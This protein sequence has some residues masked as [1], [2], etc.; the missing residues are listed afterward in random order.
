MLNITRRRA[1]ADLLAI[2]G[3]VALDCA[4]NPVTGKNQLMLISEDEEIAIG[5]QAHPQILSQFGVYKD[6][7]IQDFMNTLGQKIAKGSQR[8]DL[9][10]TFTVLDSPVVNAFAAPGGYI[11]LNRGILAYFNDEAQ[12]AGVLGHEIGHVVARHSAAQMSKEELVNLGLG[13]G[14]IF[15]PTIQ[16]F[17]QLLSLGTSVLFLKF[18]RDNERMADRLGVDYSTALGYDALHMSDFYH[19]FQRMDPKGNDDLPSWQSTHPDPGDRVKATAQLARKLQGSIPV[20]TYVCNRNQYLDRV[21]GMMFGDDPKDGYMKDGVFYHPEMKFR[22]AAPKNWRVA[23]QPENVHIYPD[24]RK[25][26]IIFE[27]E[28]GDTPQLAAA[29]FMIQNRFETDTEDSLTING[30]RAYRVSGVIPSNLPLSILSH[31]IQMDRQV[32]AFHGI[33]APF[34]M[35]SYSG[36]FQRCARGFNRLTDPARIN[37]SVNRIQVRAAKNSGKLEHAFNDF[38]VPRDKL[39]EYSIINGMNLS[40]TVSAGMRIKIVE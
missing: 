36:V 5:R 14:S 9:K 32:Y 7:D 31:Y 34:D 12:F 24:N 15:S 6:K 16:Q 25:A 40:D 29:R 28:P 22:F 35:D 10:Y 37:V 33:S 8:N 23:N 11:Y 30:F 17:S 19:T 39:K 3:A 38:G 27:L 21:D 26:L 1:L 4:R 18:S 20:K 2:S 13:L